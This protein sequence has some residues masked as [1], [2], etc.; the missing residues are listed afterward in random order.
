MPWAA[1]LTRTPDNEAP[2]EVVAGILVD[3]QNRVLINE[4]PAGKPMAGSWEFP[5]GKLEHGESA[6]SGLTRELHEELGIRVLEAEPLLD[7][8]HHYPEL[9][10]HLDVWWVSRW[11]GQVRS[12]DGQVLR[13]V[14]ADV[15]DSVSLLPAD[16]PIVS[17]VR[18]RLEAD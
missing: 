13:W 6:K 18:L 10:V 1:E 14:A 2:I 11:L 17:A 5:G 12:R 7:L 16:A 8:T 9:S 4:R 3:N 15:L